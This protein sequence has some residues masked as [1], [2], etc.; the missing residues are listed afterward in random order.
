[1]EGTDKSFMYN[2]YPQQEQAYREQTYQQERVYHTDYSTAQQTANV[3]GQPETFPPTLPHND[4]RVVAALTY[5]FGWFSGLIFAIFSRN[6]YV[7]FHALQSLIFFGGINLIDMAAPF[8]SRYAITQ[9]FAFPR[10]FVFFMFLFFML[11]NIVAF[12]GWIVSITQAYRGSYYRLPIVGD[13]V[14]NILGLGA[15]VKH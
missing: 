12:I 9:Y 5:V 13:I 3:Y 15:D 4:I 8:I 14:A 1:M 2:D 7:R 10:V 6:R 11:L